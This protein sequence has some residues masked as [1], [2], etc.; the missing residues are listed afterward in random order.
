MATAGTVVTSVTDDADSTT[1]TLSQTTAGTVVE[2]SIG[3]LHGQ[4]E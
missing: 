1:V 3:H 2:G 4:C